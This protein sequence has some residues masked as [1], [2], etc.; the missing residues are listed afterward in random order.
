VHLLRDFLFLVLFFLLRGYSRGWLF[1]L[2][3]A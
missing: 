3:E 2:Q 1:T